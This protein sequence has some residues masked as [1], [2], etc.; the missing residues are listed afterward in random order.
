MPG[1]TWP[2][3]A[4][5]GSQNVPLPLVRQIDIA[6]TIARLLGFEMP[7]VDGVAMVGLLR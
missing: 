5:R 7:D 4:R 2:A 1:R 6:P 3:S